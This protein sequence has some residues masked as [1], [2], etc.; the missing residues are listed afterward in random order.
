G[1]NGGQKPKFASLDIT[2]SCDAAVDVSVNS[3]APFTMEAMETASLSTRI[4]NGNKTNVTITAS[5]TAS[6]SVTTTASAAIQGGKTATA[7]ITSPSSS[8]LA[9]TFSGAGLAN[10]GREPAIMLASTSGLLPLLWIGFVLGRG[11]RR[12]DRLAGTQ[13]VGGHKDAA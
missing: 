9:I 12:R 1:H 3:G 5:L 7:T 11:P 4:E 13:L 8:T 6:P 10:L 2:N